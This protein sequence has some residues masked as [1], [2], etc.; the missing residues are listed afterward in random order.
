MKHVPL[1]KV[2]RAP[3]PKHAAPHAKIGSGSQC[4]GATEHPKNLG[5]LLTHAALD[6]RTQRD[7]SVQTGIQT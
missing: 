5:L 3:M 6:T 7:V 1:S 4:R 2:R